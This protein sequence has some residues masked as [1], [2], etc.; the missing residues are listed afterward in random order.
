MQFQIYSMEEEKTRLCNS[1]SLY[2]HYPY[3]NCMSC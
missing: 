3:D 1:S 2:S